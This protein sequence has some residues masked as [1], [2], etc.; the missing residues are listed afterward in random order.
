M[1]WLQFFWL[2]HP[3]TP[4]IH[5]CIDCVCYNC[6][7]D[8]QLWFIFKRL[9]NRYS[10]LNQQL[11]SFVRI[12]Y[13]CCHFPSQY[14][15]FESHPINSSR[16]VSNFLLIS[17]IV[18]AFAY[19]INPHI[20]FCCSLTYPDSPWDVSLSLSLSLGSHVPSKPFYW[21][22]SSLVDCR[23]NVIQSLV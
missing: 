6:C 12:I 19:Q 16:T 11:Y 1:L 9:L 3:M 23:H 14:T 8:I 17:T 22:L 7:F 20:N 13:C 5:I 2:P 4:F 15:L 10:D 21:L 18:D